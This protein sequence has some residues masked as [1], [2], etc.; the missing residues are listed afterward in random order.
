M[1]FRLLMLFLYGSGWWEPLGTVAVLGMA[2]AGRVDVDLRDVLVMKRNVYACSPARQSRGADRRCDSETRDDHSA[3]GP[4]LATRS[5]HKR[6]PRGC[7]DL[8]TV[9]CS[10][11]PH[12]MGAS[13]T[14][15]PDRFK[16]HAPLASSLSLDMAGGYVLIPEGLIASRRV[17]K[18]ASRCGAVLVSADQ[19]PTTLCRE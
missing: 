11:M 8:V 5:S 6:L 19:S 3:R 14:Q 12:K 13:D 10:Y 1:R 18:R 17:G 7:A 16:L 15:F 4:G 2:R 9:P